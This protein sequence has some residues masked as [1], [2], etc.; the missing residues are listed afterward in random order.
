MNPVCIWEIHFNDKLG[1]NDLNGEIG[2]L[3][4]NVHFRDIVVEDNLIIVCVNRGVY[5]PN[6]ELVSRIF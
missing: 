5:P 3:R 2:V 6:R 1:R 4:E